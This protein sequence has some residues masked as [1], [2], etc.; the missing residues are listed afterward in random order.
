M[1][2]KLVL[3]GIK[4][5]TNPTKLWEC[6]SRK[7][8]NKVDFFFFLRVRQNHFRP[9]KLSNLIFRNGDNELTV[10][11]LQDSSVILCLNLAY[12]MIQC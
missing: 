7:I 10:F 11:I 9:D 1:R 6:L 12:Y 5:D 3:Q 2:N 8:V 4:N